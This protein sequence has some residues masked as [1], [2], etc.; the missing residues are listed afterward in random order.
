MIMDTYYFINN[1]ELTLFQ[2]EREGT[3]Y[4][5]GLELIQI[6]KDK[7]GINVLRRDC[8]YV[9]KLNDEVA[10]EEKIRSEQKAISLTEY[11]KEDLEFCWNVKFTEE[12][13]ESFTEII[14]H[15][16]MPEALG[17]FMGE[18]ME[19]FL[20]NWLESIN[21]SDSQYKKFNLQ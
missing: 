1:S 4:F 6:I 12:E 21:A 7:Y 20:I 18:N 8:G 13:W 3:D 10:Y 5:F 16:Y 17:D 9:S 14:E 2:K 15:N 11:T 19:Y